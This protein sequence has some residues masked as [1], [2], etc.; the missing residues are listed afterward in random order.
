MGTYDWIKGQLF[1]PPGP[2]S[3]AG[4][5]TSSPATVQSQGRWK[6]VCIAFD[7]E[8]TGL[9]PK[10]DRIV[11]IGA[12]KFDERGIIARFSTLIYPGIP[13]P[14]E[15]GRVNG[16][17]DT[18]LEGKPT[19]MEVLPDFLRFIEGGILVAHNAPFDISFIQGELERIAQEAQRQQ[20][21]QEELLF[22]PEGEKGPSPSDVTGDS[23]RGHSWHPPYTVLPHPVIDTRILAKEL[24]PNQA[25][26]SLQD[27]A[28]SLGLVAK[29][30]HRAEDDARLCMELFLTCLQRL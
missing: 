23:L 24:F 8:T 11:E 14:E 27:L 22:D 9:D 13:M 7:T 4:E 30:A 28:V 12:V 15:A 18:M 20:S 26:Y 21:S 2:I 19:A 6:Q 5:E 1:V 17:T 3:K 16:I 25:R 29:E 10:R